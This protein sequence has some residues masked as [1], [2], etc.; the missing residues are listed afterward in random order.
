[1]SPLLLEELDPGT[2]ATDA[3]KLRALYVVR[4]LQELASAAAT[5]RL[6]QLAQTG[7]IEGRKN[8]IAVLGSSPEPQRAAPVLIGIVKS[9][10]VDLRDSALDA[11]AQLDTQEGDRTLADSLADSNPQVVKSTLLALA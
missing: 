10:Q 1:M 8:A 5:D 9:N 7:T 11:L 2:D 6:V 3:Q 4:A